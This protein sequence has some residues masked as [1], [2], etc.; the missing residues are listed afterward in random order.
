MTYKEYKQA[1]ANIQASAQREQ[2]HLQEEMAEIKRLKDEK[3]ISEKES[4]ER[5]Q[6]LADAKMS[7]K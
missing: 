1:L 6:K 3:V 4:F 2:D 5:D 7:Y